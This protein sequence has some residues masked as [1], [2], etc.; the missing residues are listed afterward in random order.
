MARESEKP[1]MHQ[2]Y[3]LPLFSFLLVEHHISPFLK[4]LLTD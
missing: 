4:T 3:S 1:T 2:N